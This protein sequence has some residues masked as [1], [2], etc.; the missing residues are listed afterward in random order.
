MHSQHTRLMMSPFPV[1][2]TWWKWPPTAA[3]SF[4][5]LEPPVICKN[6]S[7]RSIA[8]SANQRPAN[9][10]FPITDS[11]PL[12]FHVSAHIILSE[13]ENTK[14]NWAWAR[15]TSQ[16]KFT[17]SR[18]LA[19]QNVQSLHTQSMV[20]PYFLSANQ[21]AWNC[22]KNGRRQALVIIATPRY[23]N[24]AAAVSSHA[25]TGIL[26]RPLCRRAMPQR[27]SWRRC[28]PHRPLPA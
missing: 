19:N 1:A 27:L 7:Q 6:Q 12:G 18:H 15:N 24:R 25:P 22:P 11:L 13:K 2:A 5:I 20:K 9:H 3:Q 16:S 4:T 17:I 14:R 28:A 8:F 21:K 10:L 26:C 23:T